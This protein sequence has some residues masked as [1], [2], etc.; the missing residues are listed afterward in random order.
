MFVCSGFNC[1][2]SFFLALE[3]ASMPK[4]NKEISGVCA[5]ACVCREVEQ[6]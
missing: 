3:D 5:C 6:H 1:D 2:V 4:Y